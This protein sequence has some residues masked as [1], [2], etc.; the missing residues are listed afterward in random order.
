MYLGTE[1]QI[2]V[3]SGCIYKWNEKVVK[4]GTEFQSTSPKAQSLDLEWHLVSKAKLV[5][6][7][8]L[9]ERERF[10]RPKTLWY[11]L[12]N[13]FLLCIDKSGLPCILGGVGTNE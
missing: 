9:R 8:L 4:F 12:C 1:A 6:F 7:E 10:K 13:A 3:C 11:R 5:F 2:K